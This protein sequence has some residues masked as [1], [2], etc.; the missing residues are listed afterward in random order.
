VVVV[1]RVPQDDK[2][3]A[4]YAASEIA[5]AEAALG[6]LF[7]REGDVSPRSLEALEEELAK[8]SPDE[9]S[10][11][12]PYDP[13]HVLRRRDIDELFD[14]SADLSGADL[15]VSRYI[16][17]GDARDVSVFWR[18]IAG[19]P[20]QLRLDEPARREELCPVP[21]GEMRSWSRVAFVFDYLEGAW[22]SR[23]PASLSPGMI[24]LLDASDGGYSVDR[25]WVGKSKPVDPVPLVA[26]EVDKLL[27][28]S[29][30]PDA[31]ELSEAPWRTI[32]THGRETE[33][34]AD[35]LCRALGIAP[36]LTR[37]ISLAGRWHDAGKAHPVF[38]DAIDRQQDD[39]A[40]ARR[41]L[42]KAPAEAWKRPAYGARPGFRHELASTLALFELLRLKDPFHAALLG[43]HQELF[44]AV[45]IKPDLPVMP[46]IASV[47]AEEIAALSA[48]DF[49]LLAWLVCTHHGKVRC[50]WTSTPQDQEGGRGDIHGVRDG[51]E[52]PSFALPA[53]DG[54]TEVLPDLSLSLSASE[55]GLGRRYGTC[56]GERVAQ[57]RAA[58]GPFKL[59]FL[60]A[61]LRV[62][63]WRASDRADRDPL[64]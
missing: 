23:D 40:A 15:D 1:G 41:D 42:A 29:A 47:L 59:A 16:R 2:A 60:E 13:L 28:S 46:P 57:L 35:A 7:A 43:P 33:S 31:D 62:A 58:H 26:E 37:I 49:N 34:E 14:T 22:T 63:D 3:A 51:D 44:D 32:A 6:H 30:S 48:E 61:L 50:T 11:L 55:M 10:R 45:G 39:P 64:L 5:A 17:S 8:T 36:D 4:P 21:I 18:T 27:I 9:I 24:V 19:H 56:W 52:L 20:K 25:G 38:Q 53:G 54:A 12:Y